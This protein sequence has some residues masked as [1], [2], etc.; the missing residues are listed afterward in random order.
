MEFHTLGKH[1]AQSDCQQLDF[2]PF[3][4][5]LCKNIYCLDHRE[6]KQHNCSQIH[7]RKDAVVPVC[8]ACHQICVLKKGE[9]PQERLSAHL[10]AGCPDE[11][12]TVIQQKKTTCSFRNCHGGELLPVVCNDCHMN[13]CLKHRFPT[14]HKCKGPATTSVN[15]CKQ[16]A[17]TENTSDQ[18]SG[19]RRMNLSLLS[20]L[21]KA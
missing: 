10:L 14:A 15:T 13:F 6:Y 3:T 20:K 21:V 12:K 7:M 18:P 9:D 1:C 8:P 5:D 4:C 11:A 19:R 17:A 16:Q 2:L